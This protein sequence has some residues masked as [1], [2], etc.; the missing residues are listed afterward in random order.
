[1]SVRAHCILHL[2][3][4]KS[5]QHMY[6]CGP[7]PTLYVGFQ[8]SLD[9]QWDYCSDQ[10]TLIC[11]HSN[12]GTNPLWVYNGTAAGGVA[13][14]NIPGAEYTEAT[15]TRHVAVIGGIENVTAL[16]SFTFQCVYNLLN[17]GRVRSNKEQYYWGELTLSHTLQ[18][19]STYTCWSPDHG[20]EVPYAP[21]EPLLNH[22]LSL[23]AT[24]R[25]P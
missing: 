23:I 9:L 25:R 18:S 11:T 15:S 5:Y 17:S 2:F 4:A 19:I 1:M 16:D 3:P 8:V 6:T 14:D 13:L 7:F 24:V 22:W 21:P 20:R 10:L 12:A